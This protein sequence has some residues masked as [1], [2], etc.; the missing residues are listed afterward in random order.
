MPQMQL[1]TRHPP[2]WPVAVIVTGISLTVSWIA[3][4]GYGVSYGILRL[5]GYAI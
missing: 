2:L 1:Q 4:L 3:V 5:I